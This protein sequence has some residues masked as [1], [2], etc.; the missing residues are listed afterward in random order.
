MSGRKTPAQTYTKMRL[1][2]NTLN[3]KDPIARLCMNARPDN[4]ACINAKKANIMT[5]TIVRKEP[6]DQDVILTTD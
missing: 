6:R 3:Q 1:C 2:P 5:T 4:K